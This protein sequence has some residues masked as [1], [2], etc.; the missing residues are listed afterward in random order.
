MKS[1][2]VWLDEH[3]YQAL[4]RVAPAG[5]RGRSQFVRQAIR[6]AIRHAEYERMRLAYL[7]QPDSEA[8]ASDWSTPE[9]YKL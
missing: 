5:K 3:T 1:I 8:G 7:A 2:S 9:E 4:N 6:K